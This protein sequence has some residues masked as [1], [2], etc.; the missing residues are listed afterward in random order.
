MTAQDFVYL[1]MCSLGFAVG[2][3][4]H[5]LYAEQP[6]KEEGAPWND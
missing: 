1:L 4:A 2:W 3:L 6:K 5:K